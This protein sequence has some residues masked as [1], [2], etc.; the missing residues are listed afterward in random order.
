MGGLFGSFWPR[1]KNEETLFIERFRSNYQLTYVHFF[2]PCCAT[3]GFDSGSGQ[4][5]EASAFVTAT[6]Q[7]CAG[8]SVFA[9]LV[10]MSFSN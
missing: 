3:Y 2:A 5:V 1:K 8:E 6:D 4:K 7:I 10:V 9:G